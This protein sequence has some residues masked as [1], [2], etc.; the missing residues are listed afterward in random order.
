[1]Q[2]TLGIITGIVLVFV[3]ALIWYYQ[4]KKKKK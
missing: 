1:M 2:F 3:F 4:D